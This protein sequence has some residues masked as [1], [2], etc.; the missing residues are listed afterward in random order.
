MG[1]YE[2]SGR[3]LV[4]GLAILVEGGLIILAVILGRVLHQPPL[5]HFSFDPTSALIGIIATVPL[6]LVFLI[7]LRWPIGPIASIRRF[8]LE[9][10]CP[11]LAPCSVQDLAA[12]AL[13]AGVGEE[14]LFR[15]VLQASFTHNAGPWL[16]LAAASLLFGLLHAVTPSY[17]ILA[18]I[19]GAYLGWLW[20]V[21]GN[22]L[23]PIIV[24]AL[25]D[26][27]V[28]LYLLVGPGRALWENQMMGEDVSSDAGT[29]ER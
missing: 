1:R 27:V 20:Q 8:T 10:L 22:L 3:T 16:G 12:I 23:C 6:L 26:F 9:V 2:I 21:T 25:Y 13:L 18:A 5:E 11:V 19:M 29:G 28:L 17:A 4:V 7:V 15:G 24:H 14:M